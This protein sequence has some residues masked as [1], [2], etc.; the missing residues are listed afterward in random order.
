MHQTG[1]DF[2]LSRIDLIWV[3]QATASRI[4]STRTSVH[5]EALSVGGRKFISRW[6]ELLTKHVE[7]A[8]GKA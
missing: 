5:A 3:D 4:D 6:R 1:F 2:I 7:G 8:V